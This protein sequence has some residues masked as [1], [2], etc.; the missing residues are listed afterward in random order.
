MD[1]A[2]NLALRILTVESLIFFTFLMLNFFI[3]KRRLTSRFKITNLQFLLISASINLILALT[4]RWWQWEGTPPMFW[5]ID[6]N[7]WNSAFDLSPNWIFNFILFIPAAFFIGKFI[8]K[9]ASSL[10]FFVLLSFSIET[11]QGIFEWGSSD[12]SDWV[13]NSVGSLFG[14]GIAAK[15]NLKNY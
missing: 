14:L 3:L 7:A 12:P 13:A 11:I 9:T 10:I 8:K 1:S 2:E 5:L 4:F 6:T 15:F